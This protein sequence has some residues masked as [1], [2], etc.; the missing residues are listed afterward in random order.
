MAS[1]FWGPGPGNLGPGIGGR[2]YGPCGPGM[3]GRGSGILVSPG[4]RNQSGAALIAML[5]L[6]QDDEGVGRF[7]IPDGMVL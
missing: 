4:L 5:Y 1:G 6:H 3:G 7:P 2:G